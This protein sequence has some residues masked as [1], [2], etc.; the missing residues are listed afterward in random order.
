MKILVTGGAGFIGSFLVDELINKGHKVRIFDNLEDQVHGGTKPDY[1]N[2][3][4]EFIRGDI[5]NYDQLKKALSEIEVVYHMAASVGVA[6]SNYEIKK[7]ID[8]NIGGTANLLDILVNSKTKVKKII[9]NSSMTGLGEGNYFCNKCKQIVR[10]RLRNEKDVKKQWN[11]LC[12]VCENKIKPVATPEDVSEYPNSIYAISKKTQQDMLLHFGKTYKPS[13]TILRCF[14]VYGPR[15]SLSNPYTGVTAI[16]TSRIKNNQPAVVYED[17]MQTRDFI[18]VH[19]VVKVLLKPLTNKNADN[20]LFNIGSG[21]ATPIKEI[22]LTIARH[23]DKENLVEV[24]NQFRTGDIRH[25]FA[26]IRK[27]KK[28]LN[29]EPNVNLEKGFAEMIAWGEKQKAKDDFKK[30]EK[31]LKQKGLL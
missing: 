10:P 8:T 12:P 3:K 18:S 22:A 29:W 28:L 15:Q 27:A 21:K 2:K 25:C 13:V 6:Q 7:Y 16:F 20:Q 19:D 11:P 23:F 24:R 17:G 31:E 9:C 26:D 5:R 30:S 1:L 14:N 4:A